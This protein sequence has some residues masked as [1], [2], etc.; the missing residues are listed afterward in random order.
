M[1]EQ[2]RAK[3]P[4]NFAVESVYTPCESQP[5]P[6]TE[7]KPKDGR[8]CSVGACDDVIEPE[9]RRRRFGARSMHAVRRAVRAKILVV[10]AF[11][12]PTRLSWEQ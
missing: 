12:I 8:A 10:G 5:T 3:A 9:R 7:Y 4:V 2:L 11:Y 6:S 1:P